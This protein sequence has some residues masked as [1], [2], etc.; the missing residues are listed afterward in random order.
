MTDYTISSF[1]GFA[2]SMAAMTAY[3]SALDLFKSKADLA[4][5]ACAANL[6]RGHDYLAGQ[7]AY[8][9]HCLRK[10]IKNIYRVMNHAPVPRSARQPYGW[11]ITVL[12]EV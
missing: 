9:Y 10:S 12:D 3:S 11:T 8:D 2:L 4:A 7:N 5:H 1:Q 6:S